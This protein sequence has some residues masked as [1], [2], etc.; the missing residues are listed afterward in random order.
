MKSIHSS[1]K[2]DSNNNDQSF[3]QVIGY[4]S[5]DENALADYF[6]RNGLGD[7]RE[8]LVNHKINGKI[9]PLLTDDDL[10][11]MGISIVGD[12]C[13]FRHHIKNLS[14]K[15]R[16]VQ[17]S[18]ILWEAKERLFFG[19]GDACINTC[20]GLLPED[21]STYKLT[22]SHL[23]IRQVEPTRCGPITFCC[24]TEYSVNNIDLSQVDD[25]DYAFKPAPCVQQVF[26][27][28]GGKEIVD[29]STENDGHVFLALKEGTGEHS[30]SLIMNQVEESQHIERD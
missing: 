6:Q 30:S 15:A 14:K 22:S 7:Y 16:Q 28:A 8:V 26:C 12:R 10:K 9:A 11:D 13:R 3:R 25:V 29:V 1:N 24:C 17:R 20:C 21:P 5:W 27:C 18:K 23:K 2:K 19:R 4:E